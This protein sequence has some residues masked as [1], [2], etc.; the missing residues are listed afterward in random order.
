MR[1]KGSAQA[2]DR[3]RGI[4]ANMFHRDCTPAQIAKDLGVDDQTVRAWRRAYRKSGREALLSRKPTGRPSCLSDEQRLQ[5]ADLLEKSPAECGFDK[6][7]WTQQ[8][9]ADPRIPISSFLSI[10]R[11][12]R[13]RQFIDHRRAHR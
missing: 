13:R 1:K 10:A 5:L 6:H 7:L 3:V 8:L 12:K 4:A 9:I 2:W 11:L